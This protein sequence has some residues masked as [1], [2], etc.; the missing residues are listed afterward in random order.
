M[1]TRITELFGIRHPIV[2]SGMGWISVP[3][4]VAAV[5]EA[6]GLGILATGPLSADAIAMGSRFMT[7][8]ESAL[9]AN[10]KKKSIEKD[11]YDT[12]YS[13]RFDGIPCRLMDNPASR[14]ALKRGLN[15][16]AAF[17][18]ARLIAAQMKMPFLK[19]F[20]GVMFSGWK[21]ARQLAYFANAFKL[22]LEATVAAYQGNAAF[23]IGK[24]SAA[25]YF[26]KHVL[27]EVD[28]AVTSIK[29]E[30]LSM[31]DLPEEASAS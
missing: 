30:D 18:N 26:I 19:L 10:F 13:T 22:I 23:Y 17:F 24:V 8:R 31:I 5:S 12:L 2:L 14:K 7:T 27:P 28:A 11:I 21:N 29:S 1:K 9:H 3:K 6:G 15:L 20:F 25:R 4:M 16:P